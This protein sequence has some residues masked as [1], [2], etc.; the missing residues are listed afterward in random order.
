MGEVHGAIN[1]HP[2]DDTRI[3]SRVTVWNQDR[4]PGTRRPAEVQSLLEGVKGWDF[5]SSYVLGHR[6]EMGKNKDSCKY[7][8]FDLF[9]FEFDIEDD[10]HLH[11]ERRVTFPDSRRVSGEHSSRTVS[12]V[13]GQVDSDQLQ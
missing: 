8:S 13:K 3:H 10:R 4:L 2:K 1:S 11:P 9:T 7:L 12:V 5:S 6:L